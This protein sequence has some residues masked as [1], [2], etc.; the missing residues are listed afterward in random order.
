[1]KKKMYSKCSLDFFSSKNTK[2]LI[3]Y[4]ITKIKKGTRSILTT[5]ALFKVREK[6]RRT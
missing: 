6:E 1:L 4:I 2:K 5:F 3:N